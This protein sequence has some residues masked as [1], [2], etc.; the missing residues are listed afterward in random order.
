MKNLIAHLT[1]AIVLFGGSAAI[2]SAQ[3]PT[4]FAVGSF[5][6]TAAAAKTANSNSMY[7]INA[8]ATRYHS[9]QMNRGETVKVQLTGDG[10]TDLDL[11]VYDENG[12]LIS[13]SETYSDREYAYITANMRT[14]I[15]V[16]V[17]NRDDVYN[18]YDLTVW[19]K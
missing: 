16:K 1:I 9:Y 18:D 6:G 14:S 19:I 8:Y 2:A 5:L 11:Y 3:I 4:V 10:D 17:V 12:K 7:R 15:T 13:K